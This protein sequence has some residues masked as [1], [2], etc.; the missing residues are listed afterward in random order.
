MTVLEIFF[1]LQVMD[2]MTT[3]VGLRLGGA[4]MSPFTRWMMQFDT[5][6]G[7]TFVKL[8]GFGLGGLCVYL[9][10]PRVL[11]WVNYVFAGVVFWNLYQILGAVGNIAQWAAVRQ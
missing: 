2:F 7:L 5:V 9:K 4:E 3:L 1:F 11:R 6:G 8:L 10:R